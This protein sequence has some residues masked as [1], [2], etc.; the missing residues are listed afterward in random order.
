M[1]K[2]QLPE[3]NCDLG[4]GIPSEEKIF[5]WI[6]AASIACGGHY[7]DRS[8]IY[9]SL[10]LAKKF[11]KNVGAHPSY[12]DRENFGRQ[13]IS[14]SNEDLIQ[15]IQTQLNLFLEVANDL[16]FTLDH[17]KFHGALYNDA[18]KR[19]DLA[20]SLTNFLLKTYPQ[21]PVFTP[22]NSEMERLCIEKGLP[23]RREVFADRA[24]HSDYSLVSRNIK[25]SLL[26]DFESIN[27]Q[28]DPL[29]TK[30]ELISIEGVHLPI[31][32]DTLCFHGDNPGLDSFLSAIRQTWWT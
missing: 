1:T 24:Y 27:H 10:Q 7:G 18:A 11:G 20:A 30:G 2:K 29:F 22:P 21:T 4:E 23:I 32:A 3:I 19:V 28:L 17:I 14:I 25:G 9:Q 26:S 5:P 16:G 8:S 31:Q 12:P 15:S 6:D 13:S